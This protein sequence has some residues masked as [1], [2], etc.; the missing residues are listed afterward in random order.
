MNAGSISRA[1]SLRKHATEAEIRLW[2]YLRNRQLGGWKFRR[3]FP[4]DRFIT[5]FACIDAKL[6]VE[7]DGSQHAEN[8]HADAERT[9]IL[10]RCGFRVIRYWNADVLKD[11]PNVLEDILAH[12]EMRK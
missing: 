5:D 10:E 11:T 3:Q 2:H 12:L 1:R 8:A 9:R 4:V 7:L 6:I